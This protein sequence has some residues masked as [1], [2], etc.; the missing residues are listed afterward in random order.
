M[1]TTPKK[2]AK[3]DPLAPARV[4][5]ILGI[6][7]RTYP[8]VRCALHHENAWQLLV[9]TILSAQCTDVR[10]NM[11]TPVLFKKYPTAKSLAKV[12]PEEVE[13]I[14]MT[15]GF[16]RNKARTLWARR[17]DVEEYGGKVPET[18]DELLSCREWRGRRR[19]WCWDRGSDGA[20]AWW[21]IRTCTASRDGWN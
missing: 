8:D 6:L 11:V 14:I 15:T 21:W 1:A 3:Y 20:R 16:F 5:E 9:A 19:T 18:M 10:V 4:T 17:E 7:Q 12:E 13:P 2:A